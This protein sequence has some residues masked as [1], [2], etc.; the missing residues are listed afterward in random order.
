MNK[1]VSIY[2][3]IFAKEVHYI[4]VE[5][6]LNRIKNG[7]S[8]ALCERIRETIDKERANKLKSNLP[9]ICFSGKFTD[10]KDECLV[11]HSGLICLDFDDVGDINEFK[12]ELCGNEYIYAAW[13]SPSGK[14]IKALV[15]IADGLKHRE[16]FAALQDIFPSVDRS[17]VN[18][19]RV[20][21]ESYDPDLWINNNPKVFKT[22]KKFQKVVE[23]THENDT[24]ISFKNLLKW[25][26]NRGDAFVQGERNIFLFKLAS[27]CC[28][29][30]I[31]ENNCLNYCQSEFMI[32]D[33]TFTASELDR[34]VKSA[35]KSNKH[36]AGSASFE[37]ERLI[38]KVDKREV[39]INADILN[40][41]IKPKDVIFG[42]DVKA[43][44][45]K[46]YREGYE[47]LN[48]IGVPEIDT[49][50]KMKRG[51]ITL[52][53]GIG[54]YGKSTFL[55][56]Y[57]L[58]RVLQHGEK[59]A[60]FSPE[61][62]PAHEF[63]HT[64][65]EILA[66]HDCTPKNPNRISDANYQALYDYVSQHIYYVYP[67]TIAPTPEYI[68]ER[69]LELIIKEKVDGCIIDPFNQMS[70]DY[71]KAGGRDD[72]YLETFLADCSR[73]AQL[74]NIYFL[75]VAHPK[76]MRKDSD[77]NYP[78]PDIYDLANGGM[79]NNKMD[80]ILIYHRPNHQTTPDN[81]Q[82]EFH[83]KKI[84]RQNVVGKKGMAIFMLHQGRRRFL[85]D[86]DSPDPMYNVL[87]SLDIKLF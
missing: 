68:K 45:I 74:N 64:C 8:K 66:G 60:F 87:V 34:V 2:E 29:F 86:G 26:S 3:N 14:G 57:L 4:E 70:N 83:S 49:H 73:F 39:E 55:K 54:N 30:G 61:D 52:L 42:E 37:R 76:Q 10:R 33:H 1:Q 35:Y 24:Y 21:Y 58:M 32:G 80:N 36:H 22:V 7:K 53:S 12:S 41:D 75:I 81:N 71:N 44:A 59:F 67:E 11:E 72:K 38:N 40:P 65:V 46:L 84:R 43:D 6:A 82:C 16:H 47:K 62:N 5:V 51:E 23:V 20:C 77:G 15:K 18:V 9:S 27:A 25:L 78:C 31:S 85:F 48:G 63:Y 17:G 50:F 79:W 56:W 69:F 28:R 13:V 19:S